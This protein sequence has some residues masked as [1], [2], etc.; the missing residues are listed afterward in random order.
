MKKIK[1]D[2]A[3]II[4]YFKE[5]FSFSTI[6]VDTRH[7]DIELSDGNIIVNIE[8]ETIYMDSTRDFHNRTVYP[9][10]IS[11]PINMRE[12]IWLKNF[13]EELST[14]NGYERYIMLSKDSIS[15]YPKFLLKQI[16]KKQIQT[17]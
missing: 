8:K 12:L 10:I 17:L 3:F 15:E 5:Y 11:Y 14:D 7:D 6:D 2:K 9:L 16:N 13:A 1:I 4:K